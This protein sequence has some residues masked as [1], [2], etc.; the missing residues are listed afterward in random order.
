MK[1]QVLLMMTLQMIDRS[2]MANHVSLGNVSQ[3]QENNEIRKTIP[4]VILLSRTIT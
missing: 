3:V 1:S 4:N 2:V